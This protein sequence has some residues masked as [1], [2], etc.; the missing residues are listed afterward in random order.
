MPD[1]T[2]EAPVTPESLDAVQV[3][4]LRVQEQRCAARERELNDAKEVAKNAK[5][6]YDAA[7][8]ELRNLVHSLT[9]PVPAPLFEG[10]EWDWEDLNDNGRWAAL[11]R[12]AVLTEDG[13]TAIWLVTP[14]EGD[15]GR[16]TVGQSDSELLAGLDQ[17]PT[18]NT[19]AEAMRWCE[20]RDAALGRDTDD[21]AYPE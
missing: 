14:A 17:Y 18:F 15:E 7:V 10:A 6:D 12:S 2:V 11:N 5:T 9:N 20:E 3:G 16:Y 13:E 1:E 4:L 19:P 8:N 21:V